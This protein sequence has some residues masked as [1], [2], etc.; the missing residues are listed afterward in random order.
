[1]NNIKN[2]IDG[3]KSGNDK[4]AHKCAKQLISES[5]KSGDI[6]NYFDLFVDLLDSESSFDRN[7]G[8]SLIATSA[9]WDS[10]N[11]IDDIIS[12]LFRHLSDKKPITARQCVKA[13]TEIANYKPKLIPKIEKALK[14]ADPTIYNDSMCP[15]VSADIEKAL[16]KIKKAGNKIVVCLFLVEIVGIEPMTS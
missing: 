7:R 14:S 3:I 13:L 15:L 4:I 16:A 9:R 5:E 6:Y 12:L 8:L 2:L 11:K 1:M 10:E